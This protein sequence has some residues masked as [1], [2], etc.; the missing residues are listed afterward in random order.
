MGLNLHMTQQKTYN[1]LNILRPNL[2]TEKA[3]QM[4]DTACALKDGE[5]KVS[6]NMRMMNLAYK[7]DHH[8]QG[9]LASTIIQVAPD[10][11]KQMRL[12]LELN[13][14]IL[15]TMFILNHDT[16]DT[17]SIDDAALE[18]VGSYTT[19]RGKMMFPKNSSR[20]FKAQ[21]SRNIKRLRYMGLL[22]YCNYY[23]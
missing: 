5:I 11:I 12:R 14:N 23:V 3:Q 16:E 4:I 15:R 21:N 7:M 8:T 18:R 13:E 6:Q 2:S 17:F 10:R 19:K 20:A 9:Y 22:P 1:L